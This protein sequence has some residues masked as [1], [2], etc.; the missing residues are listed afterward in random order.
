MERHHVD[1]TGLISAA[2]FAS[3]GGAHGIEGWR[4]LFI[5]LGRY[6][7][8]HHF[9]VVSCRR[10]SSCTYAYASGV[11]TV[12]VAIVA[13]W[14][15]PDHPLTT[16][17]LT[18]DE[19]KLAQARMDRDTVGLEESRGPISGFKQAMSDTRLWLFVILQTLHLAACG[20]NSFFPTVVR[21]LGFS[22]TI[23]LV[24]TCPPYLFAG[25]FAVFL[26]AMSGRYNEKTW[27]ITGGMLVAVAGFAIAA[28]TLNTGA[29]Y[30][31]CFLFATGRLSLS[32]TRS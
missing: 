3:I 15:L 17:W 20:F 29:R 8:I 24:L 5:I 7:Y 28:G 32:A 14:M 2:T 6:L 31:S 9:D 16:R 27:H 12:A 26:G 11:V 10:G 30:L 25:F 4:W 21:T 19:R 13:F 23:T 22:D 18:E 1:A